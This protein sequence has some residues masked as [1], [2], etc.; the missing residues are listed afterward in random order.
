MIAH[1]EN[2]SREIAVKMQAPIRNRIHGEGKKADGS[3]IGKYSSSYLKV[4][5]RKNRGTD[6]KVILSLTGD[7]END[8]TVQPTETGYGLGFSR[9]NNYLKAKG[10]EEGNSR[11]KGYGKIYALTSE[12][13]ILAIGVANKQIQDAIQ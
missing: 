6:T 8:F 10:N 12:E 2:I 13:R 11:R 3:N 9:E 5:E 4:R 1:P 7:M